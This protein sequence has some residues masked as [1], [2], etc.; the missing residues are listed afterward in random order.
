M[1]SPL[2]T[3]LRKANPAKSPRSPQSGSLFLLPSD[4]PEKTWDE[5]CLVDMGAQVPSSSSM[6]DQGKWEE[7]KYLWSLCREK[8]H[9]AD[10]AGR[11]PRV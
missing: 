10:L 7:G 2:Q 9:S 1:S 6:P 8:T 11:D 4:H 3:V 5:V